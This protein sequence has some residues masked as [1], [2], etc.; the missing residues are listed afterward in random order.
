M[1]AEAPTYD[2]SHAATQKAAMRS[3][4]KFHQALKRMKVFRRDGFHCRYCGKDLLGTV[5][6]LAT[7]TIDHIRPKV[8]G[9]TNE[10]TNLVTSCGYCNSLKADAVVADIH[11][12]RQLI[13]ERRA[14]QRQRAVEA[15]AMIGVDPGDRVATMPTGGLADVM[16]M[17]RQARKLFLDLQAAADRLQPQRLVWWRRLLRKT[18]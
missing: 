8:A 14:E 6:D 13:A 15:L 12:A 9:G 3:E 2:A 7:A 17:A 11:E 4:Q 1:I 16:A 5:D 18:R 10:W